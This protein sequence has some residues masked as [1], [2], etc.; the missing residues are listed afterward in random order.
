M[1][2]CL[3]NAIENSLSWKEEL[4][5]ENTINISDCM[6]VKN[7]K[8]FI[9]HRHHIHYLSYHS[10]KPQTKTNLEAITRN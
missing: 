7:S 6:V 9:H 2:I 5:S 1:F 8:T 4:Q 3:P 10:K